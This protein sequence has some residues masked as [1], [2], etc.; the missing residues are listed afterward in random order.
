MLILVLSFGLELGHVLGFALTSLFATCVCVLVM[1]V[2]R[3]VRE[4]HSVRAG[5]ADVLAAWRADIRDHKAACAALVGA[6]LSSRWFYGTARHRPRSAL[7][8]V[9]RETSGVWWAH[10][11]RMLIPDF[12]WIHPGQQPRFLSIFGDVAEV[13]IGANGVGWSLL[14]LALLA[15]WQQRARLGYYAPL[16]ASLIAYVVSRP[17]FDLIRWLP[18]NAQT[19]T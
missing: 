2:W 16:L 12:P 13:G 8:P 3:V 6:T 4:R 9:R 5:V 17:G 1:I 11:I 19:S 15:L 10:P 7:V 14:L 18:S